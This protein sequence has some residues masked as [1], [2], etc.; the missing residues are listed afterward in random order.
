M[1]VGNGRMAWKCRFV[2]RRSALVTTSRWLR[3]RFWSSPGRV[4][5]LWRGWGGGGCSAVGSLG[6]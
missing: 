1:N 2:R 3:I 5:R 6:G 4:W